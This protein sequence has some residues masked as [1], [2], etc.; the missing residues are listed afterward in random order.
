[1]LLVA[2]TSAAFIAL[3]PAMAL[4]RHSSR[5]HH[6]HHARHARIH[7][8][9]FG[10]PT[11]LPTTTPTT[12]PTTSPTATVM[13]FMN[14]VLTITLANGSTVSGNVTA[15]TR[16]S[17][18]S[19]QT[20]GD[21]DNNDNQGDDD[22][23]GGDDRGGG[24]GMQSHWDGPGQGGDDQGQGDDEHNQNQ[25]CT[26]ANLTPGTMIQS[27]DLSIDSTGTATWDSVE[28]IVTPPSPP[29]TVPTV[30]DTDNDGA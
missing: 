27:A 6:S 19:P 7:H 14:G 3:T 26:T 13:S 15:D 30:P 18:V 23:G 1:M 4:A 12:T 28:L 25:M 22:N 20:T 9:R 21:D 10:E 29:T 5:R 24:P 11:T 8:R 17:C 2:V 16:I